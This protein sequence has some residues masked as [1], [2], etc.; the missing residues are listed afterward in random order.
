V[1]SIPANI[2]EGFGRYNYQ[3][4]IHYCYIAR[5]SLLEVYSHLAFAQRMDYLSID[6]H[7]ALVCQMD[8]LHKTLNG[9]ISFLKRSKQG[10]ADHPT[11]ETHEPS[12]LYSTTSTD[13]TFPPPEAQNDP[14]P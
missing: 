12:D 14:N 7:Q 4:G 13:P 8:D 1:Q 2:A 3:E 9:Y 10:A 11:H 5:G 6:K